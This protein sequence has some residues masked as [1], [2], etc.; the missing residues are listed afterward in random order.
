MTKVSKDRATIAATYT[1]CGSGISAAD[2][3]GVAGREFGNEFPNRYLDNVKVRKQ[4]R[5]TY[6]VTISGST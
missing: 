5:T 2:A 1:V 4:T 3:A 6:E